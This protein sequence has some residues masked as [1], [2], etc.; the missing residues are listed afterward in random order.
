[1]TIPF[2]YEERVYAGVL[3][4][5]IGVYLGRPFEG[6]TY[7]LIMTHL[8][9]INYYV[10]EKLDV[11]LIVTDDDISGTFTFLRALPDNGNSRNLTPAQIGQTWLN[12]I[13]ENRTILWWGGLG[14]ST[15]HTAFLR[16]KD[17]IKPPKSGSIALNS[18]VVAE[19]IGSQIFIDGWALVA[20][21]DPDL[22][23]DLA[24]RAA[25]VSHD[26]EA[27]YGAQVVAAMEAQAF[28]EPDINK[29]I[30]TAVSYIPKDSIIY[31]L[32]ADI[33]EWHAKEANW[34]KTRESIAA[35]YG[36]DKY[37]GNC[38]MVPNHALIIHALLHGEDDFQKTLMIVNT[39]G[40][41]TDCN[42]GNVGCLMGIKNGLAGIDAGPDWR[43]PVADRLYN[44]TADGGQSITDA[45]TISYQVVNIGRALN[46]LE[47]VAPKKGARF[48]FELPG[49]FQGFQ[50]DD[51]V[52]ARGTVTLDNVRGHSQQGE[53]SLAIHY[54]GIAPGRVARVETGTFIPS[55]EIASYFDKRGYSL[56]AS[57]TLYPGQVVRAG[58]SAD[59]DN[60]QPINVSLL[61]RSYDPEDR[62]VMT[63]GPGIEIPPGAYHE[64]TWKVGD[65]GGAP[66]A[67]IGL[68]ITSERRADGT[69][70]LDYLTWDGEPNVTFGRSTGVM[71]QRATLSGAG[72]SRIDMWRRAWV[73]GVDKV[74]PRWPEVFRLVQNQGRGLLIQGTREWTDYQVSSEITPHMVEASG[75]GA[76]VQGMRRYYALLLQQPGKARLVKVV[77][78]ETILAESDFSWQF[79]NTYTL[80]LQVV[81]AR[82]QGWIDGK[83]LFDVHDSGDPL[84]GGGVAL[85]CE[86][87]RMAADVVTVKPAMIT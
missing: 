51:S 29:L 3:G 9:E 16:L 74:E 85:I 36:Y 34:R 50:P 65:T 64:F 15:E 84:T 12:Y 13:I 87:G 57:P 19:Q 78:D 30:D 14:N 18:K 80:T 20:P 5:I 10:H 79:G 6:W 67:S 11:P 46:G 63:S 48:H 56:I 26:G 8:G 28:V 77:D 81:G 60:T 35:N 1:M 76:R 41:D 24:C 62:L 43:G 44:P 40:W 25:S 66:I 27:I 86:E 68:E 42:S 39:S 33:R 7:D 58:V 61:L 52:E 38:H 45:V 54:R 53:R 75:I 49:A 4:K 22:A 59:A 21:G 73:N 2:D 55:T 37:G 23:A 69:I 17:G 32:I 31:R 82:I 70:Y 47:P 72:T 71:R 83:Y